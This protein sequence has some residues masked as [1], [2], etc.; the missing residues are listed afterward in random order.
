MKA[1]LK[2]FF[3]YRRQIL[4]LSLLSLFSYS[5]F[6]AVPY[7]S[8]LFIDKAFIA[9]DMSKFISLSVLGAIIFIFST[10]VS[11]FNDSVKKKSSVKLKLSLTGKFIRKFYSLDM[12]FFQSN[13][14]G[15]NIY[16]MSD[17]DSIVNFI[18]EQCPSILVDVIKLFI[19]LAVSLYI[20][21][22]LTVF[23]LVL[24]P[25]FLVNSLY[26][27]RKLRPIYEEMWKYSALF[28][29][30]TYEAFSKILII[31]ALGLEKYQRHKY[32]KA[33][34][35][36]TRL[37]IKSFRWTVVSA[38]SSSFLSKF[39]FGL[40]TLYGGWLIIK[41]NLTIGSY[42][43][44]MLY[45]VMLG[46]LLESLSGRFQHFAQETVSFKRYFEIMN[47]KTGIDD[48]PHAKD[49]KSA[50][51]DIRFKAVSFGYSKDRPVLMDLGLSIPSNS[52]V[53]V[54]GPSGCGKTTLI[55]LILRFYD[56]D[57]GEV[58]LG[59]TPIKDIR[60]SSLRENV[61]IATQQPLLF[62]VSLEENISYGLKKI[63]R[64]EI[65]EAARIACVDEFINQ[66]P[67]GYQ[68]MAGEDACC[69]SQG[70]K[71]RI[72]IARAVIRKPLLLILDEATSSV[73]SFTEELIFNNIKQSRRGLS[74]IIISHRLFSIKDA[75]QIYFLKNSGSIEY[76]THNEL[77][78]K[79]KAYV[80]FF[81]N[82]INEQKNEEYI[83]NRR[84]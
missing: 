69:L 37:S 34:I 83:S 20:N 31:K 35:K 24:S 42:T 32:L 15:E 62:D 16:R 33:L 26:L 74:T 76:G 54:V 71:Q 67:K 80:D 18:L 53:A 10:L 41:G 6:I 59:G 77:L 46:G 40:V 38:L 28:S 3:L 51:S 63:N 43:A 19:I 36:N 44:V 5:F 27:Q 66:L 4:V 13:S 56:P 72:A 70:L 78:S 58:L 17:T 45:L 29:K 39:V 73:D 55:N 25:L 84:S 75:D 7:I 22:R 48:M 2:L 65:S 11:V 1:L 82:Q 52:W 30:E 68:T 60:L 57:S 9:K 81:H 50:Q 79:S 47:M 21:V 64:T 23:L 8:K 49:M 61:A 14:V 12:K